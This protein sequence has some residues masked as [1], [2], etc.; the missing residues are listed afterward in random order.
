MFTLLSPDLLVLPKT[1][2]DGQDYFLIYCL[3][4]VFIKLHHFDKKYKR[5]SGFLRYECFI[6]VVYTYIRSQHYVI[7]LNSVRN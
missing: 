4:I 7:L 6:R 1:A 2:T 3:Q 5:K